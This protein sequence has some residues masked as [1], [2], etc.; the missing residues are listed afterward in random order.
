MLKFTSINKENPSK[1]RKFRVYE[2]ECSDLKIIR[3]DESIQPLLDF[4]KET[5]TIPESVYR[6]GSKLEQAGCPDITLTYLDRCLA[7]IDLEKKD[8]YT[9]LRP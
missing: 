3:I 8:S 5:N 9:I 1:V 2:K 7:M 6:D 4:Y